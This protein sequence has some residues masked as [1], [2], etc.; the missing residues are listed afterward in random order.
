MI[1]TPYFVYW[2]DW[3]FPDYNGFGG[4]GRGAMK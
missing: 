2:I 4:V 1:Q 3:I